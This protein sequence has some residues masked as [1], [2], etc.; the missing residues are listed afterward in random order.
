MEPSPQV[1]EEREPPGAGTA[2]QPS[3][4]ADW[5]GQLASVSLHPGLADPVR[6]LQLH[7]SDPQGTR[8][9]GCKTLV[10]VRSTVP[11]TLQRAEPRA[12]RTFRPRLQT[13][14]QIHELL[15]V[16]TADRAGK[17]HCLLLGLRAGRAHRADSL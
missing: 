2:A 11:A 13:H 16:T 12:A 9:P 6:V 3:H 4:S 8:K 17:E 15:H 10:A 7:G 1:Q 14:L 5:L